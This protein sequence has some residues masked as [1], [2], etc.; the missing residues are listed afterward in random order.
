MCTQTAGQ[1]CKSSRT[2]HCCFCLLLQTLFFTKITTTTINMTSRNI[3]KMVTLCFL[4]LSNCVHVL[5]PLAADQ[6]ENNCSAKQTSCQGRGIYVAPHIKQLS[7]TTNCWLI[8]FFGHILCQANSTHDCPP[9]SLALSLSLQHP[10][11]K[12]STAADYDHI[13]VTNEPDKIL[14]THLSIGPRWQQ[15]LYYIV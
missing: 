5:S 8:T 6:R 10:Y 15:E 14:C 2:S 4:S 3:H 1:R 7:S 11:W 13:I 12:Q 9:L